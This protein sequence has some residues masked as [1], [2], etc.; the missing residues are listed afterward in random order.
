MH[1]FVSSAPGG[2]NRTRIKMGRGEDGVKL[3]RARD[4][5]CGQC[6][7]SADAASW[8]WVSVLKHTKNYFFMRC[9]KE[10]LV[11]NNQRLI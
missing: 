8:I 10:D 6:A 9:T 7:L 3:G 4:L 1:L 2:C 11:S 5:L